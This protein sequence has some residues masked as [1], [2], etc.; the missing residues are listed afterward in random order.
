MTDRG[1]QE[2]ARGADPV[3]GDGPRRA[4]S[5]RTAARDYSVSIKMLRKAVREKRVRTL[6]YG[7]L[8]VLDFDDLEREFGFGPGTPL[9]PPWNPRRRRS[10]KSPAGR[11]LFRFATKLR[12]RIC[13]LYVIR[14]E[15]TGR[16]KL[17]KSRDVAARLHGHSKELP[18][19]RMPGPLDC[20]R[21]IPCSPAELDA[22]ELILLSIYRAARADRREIFEAV[23]SP[24]PESLRTAEEVR[25]L[26]RTTG[27]A[28][29]AAYAQKGS[30]T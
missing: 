7:D 27:D 14:C 8:L 1:A 26:H 21:V 13:G 28:G 10:P 5:Y 12:R 25:A 9:D 23:L 4:Y 24:R 20:I 15:T 16:Y 3:I 19:D 2:R 6:L 22:L 11:Q 17:G 29:G 18:C 30:K